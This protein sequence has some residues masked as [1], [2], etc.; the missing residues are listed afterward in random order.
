VSVITNQINFNYTAD[1]GLSYVVQRSSNF[2]TW[3]SFPANVATSNPVSFSASL[4]LSSFK[5]YRVG[6]QPNP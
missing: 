2:V 5:F 3:T 6:R 1:I 4:P